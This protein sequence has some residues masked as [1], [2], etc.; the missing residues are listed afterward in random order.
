MPLVGAVL[1]MALTAI[2]VFALG[3]SAATLRYQQADRAAARIEG[4]IRNQVRLLDATLGL[5]RAEDVTDR[6]SFN[7]FLSALNPATS[8]PGMQ[9]I[10]FAQRSVGENIATALA[11]N[12]GI[13]RATWPAETT[14][15]QRFPIVLLEPNDQ[16]NAAALGYDMYSDSTRRAAMDKAAA[17]DCAAASD[18]VELVQEINGPKQPGFLIYMPLYDRA[19]PGRLRGFV[20]APFRVHDLMRSTIDPELESGISIR[21]IAGKNGVGPT[22]FQS[23][24]LDDDIEQFPVKVADRV[25]TLQIGVAQGPWA[26]RAVPITL[27]AGALLAGL[28]SFLIWLQARRAESARTLAEERAQGVEAHRLMLEEMAHRQKNSIA[29][30]NSLISLT[31][32]EV[33][34]VASFQSLLEGRVAALAAAQKQLLV[35]GD[36]A[37]LGTM[38]REEIERS[39]HEENATAEGPAVAVNERQSQPLALTFHELITNSVKYGAFKHGG[40]LDIRWVE[41]IT[42]DGK[43]EYVVRWQESGIA[44]TPDDTRE[45]FGTR[46]IR[47]LIERQLKGRFTRTASPGILL[48]EVAWPR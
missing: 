46:L 9:G 31:A 48:I 2:A 41:H 5:F 33:D 26:T 16:R 21:L 23:G 35:S 20:Y 1:V 18:I 32:R 6:A 38:I 44:G 7:R 29:R 37:D 43:N 25:W 28:V 4:R 15:A 12:Y 11:R 24:T 42:A 47:S 30:V 13:K 22:I 45:G 19:D 10:G 39:G 14:A 34:N 8:A 27:M 40:A 17:C 3:E 36:A